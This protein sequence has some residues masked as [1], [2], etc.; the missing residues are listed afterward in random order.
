MRDPY[1]E[2]WRKAMKDGMTFSEVINRVYSD[3]FEDGVNEGGNEDGDTGTSK[4]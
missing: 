1:I 3:G 4:R 2:K